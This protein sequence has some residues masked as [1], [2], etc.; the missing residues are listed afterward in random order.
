[1]YNFIVGRVKPSYLTFNVMPI[2]HASQF[3]RAA[4]GLLNEITI[5]VGRL[6]LT[7]DMNN[8]FSKPHLVYRKSDSLMS[9]YAVGD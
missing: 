8:I 5:C 7:E 6:S 2:K 1:M 3:K 4:C 9:K